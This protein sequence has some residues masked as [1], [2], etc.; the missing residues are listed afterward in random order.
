[1]LRRD[2]E[3]RFDEP[4]IAGSLDDLS[5]ADT[6]LVDIPIG[7]PDSGRRECDL[8]ARKLLGPRRGTSVFTGARR[9]ALSR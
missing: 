5:P 4:V 1:M 8:A 9:P 7:L 6:V 3:G 2:E